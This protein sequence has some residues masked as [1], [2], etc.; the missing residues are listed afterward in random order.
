M[1]DESTSLTAADLAVT[2]VRE[3]L[4][5][6]GELFAELLAAPAEFRD[7]DRDRA[8]VLRLA[9]TE[10][11]DRAARIYPTP[12]H[13][14]TCSC[15]ERFATLEE[16]DEHFWTVFVPADDTGLDGKQHAETA[17]D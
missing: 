13:A 1:S 17:R 15:G 14:A 3:L 4:K 5:V 11:A 2:P 16:L 9:L 6:A 7:T 10:A 8:R 12:P